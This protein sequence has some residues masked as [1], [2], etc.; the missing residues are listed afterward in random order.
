MVRVMVALAFR[1]A[2]LSGR[3][4][5]DIGLRDVAAHDTGS[6]LVLFAM[7]G[8]DGGL[9]SWRLE[10]GQAA[11]FTDVQAF[12]AVQERA[13]GR[14]LYEVGNGVV[15]GGLGSEVQG[16]FEGPGASIGQGIS[17]GGLSA[18]TEDIAALTYFLAGF[19]YTAD[20]TIGG[21]QCYR[22]SENGD[23]I[24][25]GQLG[26]GADVYRDTVIDL[27]TV[28]VSGKNYL[29]A[30]DVADRGV[31]SYLIDPE[32]GDL[33]ARGLMGAGQG[34]GV[35]RPVALETTLIGGN[36]F[37]VLA[38]A[39]DQG[40][41]LSVMRVLGDG[42]LAPVDHV[43]DTR[44]TRFG[45]AQDLAVVTSQ[46]RAYVLA[47]GGDGGFSLFQMLS[48]GRLV[49][50]QSY[51]EGTF[52]GVF[53]P[54]ALAA[55]QLGDDIQIFA[56]SVASGM[57]QFSLSLVQEGAAHR[58]EGAGGSLS[59]GDK[60]DIL[61]GGPGNDALSAGKGADILVDGVGRDTLTG[62]Q[63]SDIF[64]L[65]F[66]GER[67]L[68][69]GFEIGVDRL[70][71][72]AFTFLYDPSQLDYVAR[73]DGAE[74][75]WRGDVITLQSVSGQS[76]SLQDIFGG[77][78]EGPD[79]PFMGT[80]ETILGGEASDALG[81]QWGADSL[82]GYQGNDVLRGGG[83]ADM[84]YGGNGFDTLLG[85]GENDRIWGGNGRDLI[86]LGAGNDVFFDNIQTGENAHDTVYGGLGND[87]VNG[88]GGADV[89]HGKAGQDLLS[90]RRGPDQLFGGAGADTFY[91]GA[92]NDRIWGGNGRDLAYLGAGN[93]VF[94][95]NPQVGDLGRDTVFSG[96]GNDTV[97]GG[98]GADVFHGM[99]GQDLLLGRKGEDQLFG[100]RGA[101]TLDGGLGPD[102]MFG[103]IGADVFI[104]SPDDHADRIGDF[105]P[106]ED[107]IRLTGVA[108][109]A[110][111]EITTQGTAI[112][113]VGAGDVL[114]LDGLSVRALDAD[115]FLFG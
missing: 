41:A 15:V 56:T 74:L 13:V 111:L 93:D 95:D 59:G 78:F 105:T 82:Y 84:L 104:F 11:V 57:S 61:I 10:E 1:S 34:L 112:R 64:V 35:M 40:G 114:W 43:L 85:Q 6:G 36:T 81:G 66:D 17:W 49:Y 102:R 47:G 53:G 90:G 8:P 77:Y 70:D 44:D 38:S 51:A 103:G 18:T 55:V 42:R 25:L 92:G 65:D 68:I 62:G 24:S 3:D 107:R 89:F 16:Y 22:Q 58:A 99:D 37:A 96:V 110:D 72:S 106:G 113:I 63:G 21:I 76:L 67:D 33:E 79:R 60:D 115:D 7:S 30:T 91:G 87:T 100:G 39:G 75:T 19:V 69:R 31:S 5:I 71:L 97:N 29:L 109:Y 54:S 108:R 28:T 48:T 83:G 50:L 94:S 52:P 73:R 20:A 101:D 23:L 26:G 27:D 12:T 80:G 98:A 4:W 45:Q 9:A 86:Y 2:M 32:S 46:D 14:Q 88:G